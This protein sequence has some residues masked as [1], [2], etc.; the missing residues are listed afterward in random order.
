MDLALALGRAQVAAGDQSC[1]AA[2]RRP[3][4]GEQHEWRR[5]GRGDLGADEQVE[6]VLF[7]GDVGADDAGERVAVGD[8][9]GGV[10][11]LG[12]ALDELFGMRSAAEEREVGEAVE[13]G[14][15]G[16]IVEVGGGESLFCAWV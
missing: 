3:V 16:R 11:E 14:V 6:V 4:G 1:E 5:V 7:G 15:A 9:E 12:G 8:C 2:V 10:A 13:L